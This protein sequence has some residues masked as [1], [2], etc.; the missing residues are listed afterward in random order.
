[1]DRWPPMFK[2]RFCR[3]GAVSRHPKT[4]RFRRR[5]LWSFL[6]G[7]HAIPPSSLSIREE[8]TI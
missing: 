6:Q 7:M 5:R 2:N 4:S 1:M 8:E 3:R